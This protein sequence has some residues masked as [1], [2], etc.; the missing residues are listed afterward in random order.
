MRPWHLKLIEKFPNKLFGIPKLKLLYLHFFNKNLIGKCKLTSGLQYF[1][2]LKDLT[3]IPLWLGTFENTTR[4][5]LQHNLTQQH[6]FVDCGANIGLWS[7]E[8][9]DLMGSEISVHSFEPNPTLNKRLNNVKI[10]NRIKN[11]WHIHCNCLSNINEPK[12]LYVN[13][14]SHQVS[15]LKPTENRIGDQCLKTQSI[16]LDSIKFDRKVCGIKVDVEGHELEVLEGAKQTLLS[17]KPWLFIELNSQYTDARKLLDWDVFNFLSELGY[18]TEEQ[19]PDGE[20]FCKDIYL[21]FD[22]HQ[23]LQK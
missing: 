4:E 17:D 20:N 3:E 6:I 13:K 18:G 19:F 15:T 7:M 14:F 12:N 10:F 11:N 21:T 23:Q 5:F 2:S 22:T 1:V 8:A 9:L 16:K